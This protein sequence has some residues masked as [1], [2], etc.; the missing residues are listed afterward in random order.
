MQ[1]GGGAARRPGRAAPIAAVTPGALPL[2]LTVAN[3]PLDRLAHQPRSVLGYVVS[4]C[5][6]GAAVA[7]GTVL[8][9]RRPR[10]PIG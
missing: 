2:G 7:A 9:A 5:L 1:P 6:E 10:N 4:F 8:A 3:L